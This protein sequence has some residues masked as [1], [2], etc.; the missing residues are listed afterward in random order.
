MSLF[1]P[2]VYK[3]LSP[4]KNRLHN[5]QNEVPT[6]VHSQYYIVGSDYENLH[7]A[8]EPAK[9]QRHTFSSFL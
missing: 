7:T 4:G 6:P 8:R 9:I 5:P 1:L 3:E 2:I